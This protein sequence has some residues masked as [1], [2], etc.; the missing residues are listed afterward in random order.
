MNNRM[1]RRNLLIY[2]DRGLDTIRDFGYGRREKARNILIIK[3][4]KKCIEELG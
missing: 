3:R 4:K 1:L 2:R